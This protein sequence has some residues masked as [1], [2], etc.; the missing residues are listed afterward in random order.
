MEDEVSK[1]VRKVYPVRSA[2]I[3]KSQ[4]LQSGVVSESG[5]TLD[6]IHAGEERKTAET[7]ARKAVALAAAAD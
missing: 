6:E 3:H 5:P 2:V 7:A 1:A 4:L